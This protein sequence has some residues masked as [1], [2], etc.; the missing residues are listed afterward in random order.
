[1]ELRDLRALAT[2]VRSGS[3]TEA[4]LELGYTQSAVS[5]QVA[6]LE[7]EV[8]QRLLERRP[9][10]PTPAG[11]RLAEHAGRILLRMDVVRSELTRMKGTG[12][13]L[14]ID[15]CPLAV[16][17]V[18]ATAL[19]Q[20]RR[21]RPS[22]QIAVRSAVAGSAVSRLATGATDVAVIDGITAPETPLA[23]TEPGLFST[24]GLTEEPLAVA[25]PEDHPLAGRPWLDLSMLADAPWMTL[26]ELPTDAATSAARSAVTY[27]G[28]D[29]A[30][31]LHLVAAGHGTA[32][33]PAPV[34]LRASGVVAVPVRH[35]PLVHRTEVLTLRSADPP[36]TTLV[37]ELRIRARPT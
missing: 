34:L 12:Q 2:V 30:T 23:P 28:N 24:T 15:A 29:V 27:E 36:V 37:E 3:F 20:L 4:A 32:L 8:G 10:R 33:L 9:V 5:Q 1:V 21:D 25:L 18:L 19:S 6:A 17:D 26:P 35:P 11:L 16:P 7:R 14:R 31:V 22:L 13:E